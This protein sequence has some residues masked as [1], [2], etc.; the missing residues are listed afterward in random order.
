MDNRTREGSFPGD[1][2]VASNPAR[3]RVNYLKLLNTKHPLE[4]L[5]YLLFMVVG[6]VWGWLRHP[7]PLSVGLLVIVGWIVYVILSAKPPNRTSATWV[8]NSAASKSC[9]RP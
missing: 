2:T 1:E 3:L 5:F 6:C 8:P 7:G 4:L 9:G